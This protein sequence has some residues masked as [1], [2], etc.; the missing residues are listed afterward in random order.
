MTAQPMPRSDSRS[1][2][3]QRAIAA[4][5][6]GVSVVYLVGSVIE[7]RPE[8]GTIAVPSGRDL[9]VEIARTSERR[10]RGLSGRA[11]IGADGLLL[12]WPD[13][14]EHPIWM[15][16][17]RFPL[18]LVWLDV[19]HRVVAV[20]SDAQPCT[21]TQCPILRPPNAVHSVAVLELPSGHAA[22]HLITVGATLGPTRPEMPER[23]TLPRWSPRSRTSARFP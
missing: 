19:D 17:M 12:V 14:G 15:A 2:H 10:S 11:E 4:T 3:R 9:H 7:Q 18:D 5:I 23:L 13:A 20:E 1:R 16:G 21:A 22:R 8:F 6:V